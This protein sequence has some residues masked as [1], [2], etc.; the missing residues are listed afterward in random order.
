[1]TPHPRGGAPDK[2]QQKR[3]HKTIAKN[4]KA[5]FDYSIEDQFEAGLSLKGSEVKALRRGDTS[6]DESFI[7][8][9]DRG[10]ALWI[11]GYIKEFREANIMNHEPRRSRKLLLHSK[12]IEKLKSATA[13]K[14][15]T[16]L[17]LELYFLGSLVKIKI[18]LCKGR[19]EYDKRE[20]QKDRD[21]RRQIGETKRE[22]ASR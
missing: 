18:G 19:K 9:T 12:E 14:G 17:P 10:E 7:H 6:L 1:M 16:I 5:F 2:V 13:K 20:V 8:I 22:Y 4:K 3:P 11:N 21:A 15:F